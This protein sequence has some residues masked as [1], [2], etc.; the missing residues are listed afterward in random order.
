MGKSAKLKYL[1]IFIT[2]KRL[3]SF[4]K[5]SPL[6]CTD[7]TYKLI[8]QNYPVLL[9]GTIDQQKHFHPIGI[10]ISKKERTKDFAFLFKSIANVLMKINGN[11]T[12]SQSLGYHTSKKLVNGQKFDRQLKQQGICP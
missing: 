12:I 5:L 1:R 4:A 6:I 10:M 3:I 8:W 9:A 2:T 7:S 11:R